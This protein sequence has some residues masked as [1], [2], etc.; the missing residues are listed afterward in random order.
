M[1]STN[2]PR[3]L[4]RRTFGKTGFP[5]STLGFGCAPAA[6]LK[7][8]RDAAAAMINDLLDQGMNFIDT[9][10]MYPGSEEFIGEHLSGRRKEYVLVSKC[11]QKVPGH[12]APA[13]SADAVT[14][15][16][17]RALKLL[18]TDHVDVML[19][20][21]CSLDQ[22]KQGDALGA[23]V[24]AREAGK[25]KFAGYS[26]DNDAVAYAATLPDIA[27][28]ET[29]INIVDQ[30]NIDGLLPTA[31]ANNVGVIAK[32]PVANA[33]WKGMA[34]RSGIYVNYVQEYVRRFDGIGLK[35][36]DLGFADADWP[37][38]ALRFTLS[39]PEV[40]TAIVGTTNPT[41]A[42]ANLAYAA[43][44]PLPADVVAKIRAAFKQADPERKWSGQT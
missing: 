28:V 29:S 3:P 32:R 25:I 41:N 19:L 5:V 1:T 10:L 14:I 39:F 6:F 2:A 17:D 7:T 27:A 42:R 9:A 34:G 44:G 21:S 8:E 33:A 31:K 18:K 13:W 11:G 26:G 37:E 43:K 30:V 36:A 20:H 35:A 38:V 40:S 12:D 22:L 16:V 23:L 4:P 15:A 24:K